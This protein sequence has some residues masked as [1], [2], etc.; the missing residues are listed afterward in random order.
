MV[1]LRVQEYTN[2]ILQ[3]QKLI[4]FFVGKMT[5]EMEK[6]DSVDVLDFI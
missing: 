5:L 6:S 1:G 2:V 3:N 4:F